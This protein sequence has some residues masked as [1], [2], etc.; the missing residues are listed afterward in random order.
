MI[1]LSSYNPKLRGIVI[2]SIAAGETTVPQTEKAFLHACLE[3][4]M[5]KKSSQSYWD[6][7]YV[8]VIQLI[9]F[10]YLMTW[11]LVVSVVCLVSAV[12]NPAR[13]CEGI[14]L[15]S[16]NITKPQSSSDNIR[17]EW[18]SSRQRVSFPFL[19]GLPSFLVEAS[20]AKILPLSW[21]GAR[22]S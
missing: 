2:I 6:P 8:L 17:V 15:Y 16:G 7:A 12:R 14:Y 20:S 21:D 4:A 9:C 5:G 18:L 11:G 22:N 3:L 10:Y 19:E 13:C 1:Y